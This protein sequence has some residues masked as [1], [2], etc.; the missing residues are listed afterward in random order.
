MYHGGGAKK[1]GVEFIGERGRIMV[2]RGYLEA[3]PPEIL[4]EPITPQE[5]HLYESP[6]HH[7]DWLESIRNRRNPIC[8]VEIGHRSVTVCHLGNIAFWL[9]RPLQWDPEKEDFVNDADA[10]RLMQRPMRSPWTLSC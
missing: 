9:K 1:A 2:N 6:G 7:D 3:D 5:I 10:R 4:L 8:D